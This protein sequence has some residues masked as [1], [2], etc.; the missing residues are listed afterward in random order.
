MNIILLYVSSPKILSVTGIPFEMV[1]LS[2]IVF[3]LSL[4]TEKVSC[5]ITSNKLPTMGAVA[6]AYPHIN[7]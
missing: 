4:F 5:V 2:V 1:Q 7:F 6:L 3:T